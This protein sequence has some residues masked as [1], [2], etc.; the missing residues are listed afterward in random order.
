M[1]RTAVQLVAKGYQVLDLTQKSWFLNKKT[2]E[3]L[4]NTLQVAC[5]PANTFVVL[6]LFGNTS[7]KFRQADDTLALATRVGKRGDGT[8]Y[9][10]LSPH[11]THFYLSRSG[12]WGVCLP[13][14]KII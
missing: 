3:A 1:K 14:S 2:V 10:R 7:A 6:D 5:I 4:T 8:C 11:L 13:Q 12:V 9:G